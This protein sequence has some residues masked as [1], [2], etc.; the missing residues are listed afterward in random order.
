MF[1]PED[2]LFHRGEQEYM[3]LSQ[4]E[5]GGISV[6]PEYSSLLFNLCETSAFLALRGKKLPLIPY[7]NLII[8]IALPLK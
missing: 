5:F 6:W 2:F 8:F 4:R 3:E 7:C 1:I